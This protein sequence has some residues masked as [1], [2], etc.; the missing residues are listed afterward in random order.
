MMT[1]PSMFNNVLTMEYYLDA[2]YASVGENPDLC[3]SDPCKR[4]KKKLSVIPVVVSSIAAVLVLLFIFSALAIYRRKKHG[5]SS[6][7]IFYFCN[8]HHRLTVR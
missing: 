1:T 7:F 6:F 2:L 8:C 5:G 3:S 4:N